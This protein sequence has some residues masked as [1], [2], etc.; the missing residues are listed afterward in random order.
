MAEVSLLGGLV[1]PIPNGAAAV[2]G[3]SEVF[4]GN[5]FPVVV[6]GIGGWAS[7]LVSNSLVISDGGHTVTPGVRQGVLAAFDGGLVDFT[8]WGWKI[9]F[10]P[11]CGLDL[12]VVQGVRV[13]VTAYSNDPTGR[14]IT[15]SLDWGDGIVTPACP[16][17]SPVTHL[18][19]TSGRYTITVRAT[20]HLGDS[21]GL[22]RDVVVVAYP[23]RA[24]GWRP[25]QSPGSL[26]TEAESGIT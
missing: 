17:G 23:D 7:P 25:G 1:T 9:R 24:N 2:Q 22:S 14:E 15:L 18:Y 21:A 26:S 11:W 4:S 19:A 3:I 20:N 8:E 6:A 5:I 12:P 16:S 13:I 10:L